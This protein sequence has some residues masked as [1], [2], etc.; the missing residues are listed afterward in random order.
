ML[1]EAFNASISKDALSIFVCASC[2][3]IHLVRNKR[4]L[5][6][7]N[8]DLNLLRH[9]DHPSIIDVDIMDVDDSVFFIDVFSGV[10]YY[11]NQID[12]GRDA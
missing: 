10:L 4:T 11:F 12:L 3:G 8:F 2:G 1:V 9:P 5:R 6:L 7:D